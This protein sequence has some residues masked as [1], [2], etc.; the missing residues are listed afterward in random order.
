MQLLLVSLFSFSTILFALPQPDWTSY[1]SAEGKFSVSLPQTPK[2]TAMLVGTG[3]GNVLTHI[4]SANDEDL[5]EYMVTWTEYDK[6]IEYKGTEMTLDRMRD[7]LIKAKDGK[8]VN[9]SA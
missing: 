4:V 7:A 2:S 1:T 8:L 5:N 9:E 3:Q 6:D